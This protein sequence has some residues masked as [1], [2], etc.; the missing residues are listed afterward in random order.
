MLR[1]ILQ[2]I[3]V[4]IL[5]TSIAGATTL[6]EDAENQATTRWRVYDKTPPNSK[7]YNQYDSQKESQVIQFRG[8]GLRNGYI[9]GNWENRE[10]AWNNE[11]EKIISWSMQYSSPFTIYIRVMT[12]KGAKYIYYTNSRRDYG[13]NSSGRYIHLGLGSNSSNGEWQT[14]H[15]DLEADLKKFQPDNEILAVNAFLIRG[16]GSVDD[17]QLSKP[18][19]LSDVHAE[20]IKKDSVSIFWNLNEYATG[21]VEYGET[22]SYG[23]LSTKENSFNYNHHEQLLKNLKSNTLYHYKVV[24]EDREGHKVVSKDYNFTTLIDEIK[25]PT[26]KPEPLP[27]NLLKDEAMSMNPEHPKFNQWTN[28]ENIVD[29]HL[30]LVDQYDNSYYLL[31]NNTGKAHHKYTLVWDMETVMDSQEDRQPTIRVQ[32]FGYLQA[33]FQNSLNNK[34]ETLYAVI[35]S[36]DDLSERRQSLQMSRRDDMSNSTIKISNIRLYDGVIE[37]PKPKLKETNFSGYI[38]MDKEGVFRRDGKVI[39]PINIY[40]DNTMITEGIRTVEE[41]LDQGITGTLMEAVSEYWQDATEDKI[42]SI[43]SKG[44]STVSIPITNYLENPDYTVDSAPFAQFRQAIVKLKSQPEIWN[45]IG[46]LTIDNEFYHKSTQFKESIAE[47]RTLV[48]DK[49]IQILNGREGISSWYNE[50]VDI[51]GTYIANDYSANNIEI[52]EA[53]SNIHHLESQRLTPNLN[54]PATLLQVNQGTNLNFGSIVMAGVAIG[55]TKLE[56]WKDSIHLFNGFRN[57]NI[58]ENPIWDQLPTVRK[59]LDK[60]CNLGIIESTP[61]IGFKIEQTNDTYEYIKARYGKGEKAY[62]IASNMTP[63]SKERTVSFNQTYKGLHYQ[64]SGGLKDILTGEIKGEIDPKSKK[65]KITL[66]PHEWVVLEI[67]KKPKIYTYEDVE[68]VKTNRWWSR[69]AT[70]SNIFDE[71]QNSNVIEFNGN[72]VN[73]LYITGNYPTQTNAWANSDAK[74]AQ[75]SMQYSENFSVYI[76]VTT[77]NGGVQYLYYRPEEGMKQSPSGNILHGLGVDTKD[78]TWQT[79]TRNLNDDLHDFEPDNE[80][81]SVEG[82][83]IRGSGRIDEIKLLTDITHPIIEKNPLEVTIEKRESGIE[84]SSIQ[85]EKRELLNQAISLFKLSLH[86]T[87]NE[88]NQTISANSGWKDISIEGSE[89]NRSFRLSH[90]LDETLPDNLTATISLQIEGHK[91]TWDLSVEG[92]GEHYSLIEVEFP[93][94]NIKTSGEDNFFIPYHFGKLIK[95]PANTIDYHGINA[96]YPRGWGATMQFMAY[97]N[98][99]YGLYLGFHDPKASLKTFM[100]QQENS[101]VHIGSTIPIPN[102]LIANNSWNMSGAF[103]LEAFQGDWYDASLIYRDWVYKKADYRPIDTPERIARQAKIGSIGVWATEQLLGYNID[104]VERHVRDFKNFMDI[105]V[106]IHWNEWYNKPQDVDFPEYFPEKDGLGG[107]ISRLKNTYGD[108]ILISSYINGRLYDTTLESYQ[109]RGFPYATT[110]DQE[111]ESINSQRFWHTNSE[112]QRVRRTFAVMCPTQKPWKKRI[113]DTSKEMTTRLNMDGVYIDQVTAAA[114]VKCMNTTH[115]HKIGGGSY[116]R[117]G[118]KDMF[119]SIQEATPSGRFIVSEGAN[120]FLI[121][122]V[123]GFLVEPY[124]TQ[125]QVPAF[126]AVYSGKAQFIGPSTGASSY[127]AD[128]K[129]D[130][131]RFYGRLA[132]SFSF[133]VQPGRFYMGISWNQNERSARAAN[134][135]RQLARL[136]YKHRA[137]FSFGEMKKPLKLKGDIPTTSFYDQQWSD[138]WTKEEEIEHTVTIPALQTSAW[139]DSKNIL[140]TF[141]NGKTRERADDMIKFSFDF[142]AKDYGLTGEINIKE[143]TQ[144]SEG[145]YQAIS[146]QFTKELTLKSYEATTFIVAPME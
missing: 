76:L 77:K 2:L 107:V 26:Y 68:D 70:I 43:V 34:K 20:G 80:I 7:I 41:Y 66:A 4:S 141:V 50:Y 73:S 102:Q 104:D 123:D 132:Q 72:G 60:M 139:S 22:Q 144:E 103:V 124:L 88:Q 95:N 98:Q 40:K 37:L 51:T 57:L 61:Y 122:E 87:I 127:K 5:Y 126:Q 42:S 119:K 134:Y 11:D 117:E 16:N 118:Y 12:S 97:Y 1:K 110:S 136:R 54:H 28:P 56:Y 90:P 83:M 108:D 115:G 31:P 78:G 85:D 93:N 21:Q 106:G 71:N 10:G 111:G 89:A 24:S 58:K 30:E 129:P 25:P 143:V 65:I 112:G 74:I 6:Y 32:L 59:Y 39:F 145:E 48:P 55:G 52:Q 109:S 94:F 33:R 46:A 47:I 140:L 18:L 120:D 138:K 62:I 9:L 131:E 121:D 69:S 27:E 53:T 146:S 75:W 114:P 84:V 79:F 49:P 125:N 86:H 44:M 15:R 100:A 96:L 142:N 13:V 116:W 38:Q 130:A 17:I 35:I 91:S 113:I 3:V 81:L 64:P 63:M 45:G 135:L 19:E 105:P 133:G 36:K 67:E 137:F 92:L 128:E 99:K 29:G 14:F 8:K 101:G 82:L 23:E